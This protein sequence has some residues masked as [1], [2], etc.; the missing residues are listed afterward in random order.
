MEKNGWKTADKKNV[1]N[2]NLWTELDNLSKRFEIEW[3][4]VKAHSSDQLNN[5]VDLLAKKSAGL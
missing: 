5:E 2:K 1:K 4:W 3:N